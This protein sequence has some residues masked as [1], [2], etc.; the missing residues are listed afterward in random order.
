MTAAKQIKL[1][2]NRAEVN[3]DGCTKEENLE[4]EKRQKTLQHLEAGRP[5]AYSLPEVR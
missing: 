3:R 2:K 1:I 5:P 4:G